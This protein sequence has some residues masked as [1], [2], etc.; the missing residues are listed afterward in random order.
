MTD[1]MSFSLLLVAFLATALLY[2]SVGF[3]GGSTYNALLIL[4][5]LP[6]AVVPQLALACN[7]AVVAVGGWTFVRNGH[8]AF[9]RLWPL[10]ALSVP[11]AWIGGYMT[12]PAW[13]FVGLLAVAL[14]V[15]AMLLLWQPLWKAKP[16]GPAASSPSVDL[17]SGAGLGLLAGITGIGG[18]IYLSPLLHLRRWGRAQEIAGVSS[19]FILV[20]SLAGLAGQVTKSGGDAA[21]MLA[22]TYWPLFP[23]VIVGGLAGSALGAGRLREMHLRVLTALLILYVAIRLGL[24]LPAEWAKA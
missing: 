10:V 8:V 17:A 3:G 6:L 1:P 21:I 16:P 22:Q 23:T 15:A 24:R 4:A 11:A 13:L 7:I 20:N 2:S 5:A 12:V 14:A 9:G 18:G 19:W